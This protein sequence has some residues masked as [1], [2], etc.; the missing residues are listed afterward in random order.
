MKNIIF[1]LGNVLLSFHPEEYLSQFYDKKTLEDLMIIIFCSDEWLE[2]D[3][4]NMLIQEV[5]DRFCQQH[6]QYQQEITF[7][8]N[9]WTDMLCPIKENVNIL[10]QLK[11]Q[12]YSLYMLSNFHIEAFKNMQNKYDFFQL[13]DGGVISGFEHIIKPNHKIYQLLIERYHLNP[14]ESL[15]IDDSLGN[16]IASKDLGIDGI[17]LG[18]D[19]DLKNELIKKG[20]QL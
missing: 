3:L 10:K 20:I 5:I 14:A 8:L 12:G 11:N 1:D 7:V 4:G 2:L 16:I 13:F 19:V 18:Y 15:F 6:P 9:N 17:H